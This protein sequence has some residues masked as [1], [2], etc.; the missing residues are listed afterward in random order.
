M[1]RRAWRTARLLAASG[2]NRLQ[3]MMSVS[4]G[5]TYNSQSARTN[6]SP[7]L[8]ESAPR[9]RSSVPRDV[10]GPRKTKQDPSGRIGGPRDGAGPRRTNQGPVGS[11]RAHG[12]GQ[13][14]KGQIRAS[15]TK[16]DL[17]RRTRALKDESGPRMTNQGSRDKL[18]PAG[19]YIPS[20]GWEIQ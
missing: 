19:Q 2:Q 5:R 1:D 13:G 17:V 11:S 3:C 9:G 20:Q 10:T 6:Q 8:D 18:G 12:T 4:H 7:P 15:G 14:P 16:Q